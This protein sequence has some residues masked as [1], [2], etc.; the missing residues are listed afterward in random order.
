MSRNFE[1]DQLSTSKRVQTSA[2]MRTSALRLSISGC[3]KEP[4]YSTAEIHSPKLKGPAVTGSDRIGLTAKV[5][6]LQGPLPTVGCALGNRL[7]RRVRASM[8]MNS[9]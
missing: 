5:E 7:S 2:I 4:N 6:E 9:R 8:G 1:R 3:S